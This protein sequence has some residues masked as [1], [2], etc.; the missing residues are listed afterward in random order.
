M[1]HLYLSLLGIGLAA[2]TA[3]AQYNATITVTD[4]S[5]GL[6][7][8]DAEVIFDGNF[9]TTNAAGSA[10][11]TDLID[12]DYS[13]TVSK[14]CYTANSGMLTIAG[15]D[16]SDAIALEPT[17]ANNVF[18]F[19]GSPL[20]IAGATVTLTDGVDYNETLETGA[21]FGD[22]FENVPF[23]EYS[24]SISIPCYE[25]LSGNVT[26]DC[27]GNG[28]GIAVFAEPVALTAN[29]VFF[30]V[31]SP[32]TI[33][34]ATV[35]LTDGADYNETLETGAPFGDLFENVPFGEYSYSISIPCY[36][37][38]S[39]NVTVDCT[40][41][42]DGIAVFAEPVALTAN[43]VFFFVGSPMTIAGATVT[44]TDGADYNETLETGA[45]FGDLFENVPFG[46]YSY[47]ISIP[48]YEPVSGNVTVDCTGN[49]DGIAVFAEPVA[50]TANNVFFFVGSPLTIAGAT[51]TLTDGADYNETLETGAPF[52]DLFE[53][54]PFGEYSY[55]ISIPC[56][57]PVSGN[58]TVDCT[59]GDGIA[60]FAEPV[61]VIID[62][63]VTL[64]SGTLTATESG[65]DYQWVDC[66]DSNA[67]IAGATE[68]SYTATESGSYAVILT[69][70]DCS[71]T[72]ECTS[73]IVN[74][75]EDRSSLNAFAVYP[76]PFNEILT[77]RSNGQSG[78]VHVELINMAGQMLRNETRTGMELITIATGQLAPGSYVVR[79][80]SANES[81]TLSVIK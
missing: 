13:S 35:T 21:P 11:F 33:A 71:V 64:A 17:T 34:G 77:V 79:L 45:P 73:V 67:P 27:T 14:G 31:G 1:K 18:F 25:P 61:E 68:Q 53:N 4:L 12:F 72:S 42:G 81:T 59:T 60:V 7:L 58:V 2:T 75:V 50:L 9:Q 38:L 39:G 37:P 22:L 70:G 69:M 28:D 76:N 74:G 62:A 23:G 56:Y 36:E 32:L 16:N 41:N 65:L 51:V 5:T 8:Q 47:S 52:G 46:E 6:P 48:C 63:T 43:A 24:Y 10:V 55:S 44:L 20:T 54:V 30:F 80:T 26:V 15:A 19:V 29:A 3:F 49:G 57:E 40:G 66:D 78:V